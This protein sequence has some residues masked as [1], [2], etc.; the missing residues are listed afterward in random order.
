MRKIDE[1]S[2]IDEIIDTIKTCVMYV[3]NGWD[4][5]TTEEDAR[6]DFDSMYT[7]A[8]GLDA[9]KEYMKNK[10]AS[11][12]RYMKKCLELI[13]EKNELKEKLEKIQKAIE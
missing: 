5:E 9:I 10:D 3:I 12:E 6:E 8:L 4:S 7:I 1:T 13:K 2:T 11:L